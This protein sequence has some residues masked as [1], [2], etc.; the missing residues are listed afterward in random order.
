MGTMWP[1]PIY[2]GG[3]GRRGMEE[4]HK[5]DNSNYFLYIQDGICYL[6][7]SFFVL[8]MLLKK[9]KYINIRSEIW[10]VITVSGI[11]KESSFTRV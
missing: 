7:A 11:V 4:S 6:F 3:L 2:L 9:K 10:G 5:E 1:N 8:L